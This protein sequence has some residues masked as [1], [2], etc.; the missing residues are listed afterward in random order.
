MGARYAMERYLVKT[1]H[2]VGQWMQRPKEKKF[3]SDMYVNSPSNILDQINN[4]LSHHI[5][6]V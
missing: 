3:N 6:I 4:S 2:R 1:L 5:I